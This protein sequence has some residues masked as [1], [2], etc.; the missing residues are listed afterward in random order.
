MTKLAIGILTY[1]RMDYLIETLNDINKTKY[2]IELIILNN[3]EGYCVKNLILPRINNKK[4]KCVI[5]GIR[6]I[7]VLQKVDGRLLKIVLLS[8]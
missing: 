5:F 1:K 3:N 7:M 4:Y 8:S 2:E 6:Q